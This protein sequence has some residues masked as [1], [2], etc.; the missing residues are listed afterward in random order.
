MFAQLVSS[1]NCT[2]LQGA[3]LIIILD[4]MVSMESLTHAQDNMTALFVL[5]FFLKNIVSATCLVIV[6]L[7]V[8]MGLVNEI[9]YANVS[10]RLQGPNW[11]FQVNNCTA[12]NEAAVEKAL[13][14]NASVKK[15]F[16]R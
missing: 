12:D 8:L 14:H 5:G 11:R 6:C 13:L 2:L 15:R 1:S 7:L 3:L 9:F 10:K 16:E 4:H